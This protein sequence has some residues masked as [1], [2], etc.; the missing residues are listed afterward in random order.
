MVAL[1]A[2]SVFH[3]HTEPKDSTARAN[4]FPAP[5]GQFALLVRAYVPTQ[6]VRDGLYKLP[7]VERVIA[8]KL[9]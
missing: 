9:P 4:W 8:D 2:A 1:S 5:E 6:A 3:S 7:N